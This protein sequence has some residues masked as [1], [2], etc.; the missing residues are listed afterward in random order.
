MTSLAKPLRRE[1]R[2]DNMGHEW[3]SLLAWRP[4]WPIGLA[5]VFQSHRLLQKQIEERDAEITRLRDEVAAYRDLVLMLRSVPPLKTDRKEPRP[6]VRPIPSGRPTMADIQRKNR[7]RMQEELHQK[8]GGGSPEE[9][10]EHRRRM[11]AEADLYAGN[12]RSE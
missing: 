7:L 12:E 5:S 10:A 6:E 9:R 4:R 3:Q 2:K 1:V 11:T 8:L